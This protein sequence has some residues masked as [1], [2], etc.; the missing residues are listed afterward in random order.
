M[1]IDQLVN[2]GKRVFENNR[3]NRYRISK[4]KWKQFL[5]FIPTLVIILYLI[6]F[7]NDCCVRQTWASSLRTTRG[8]TRIP[9]RTPRG[10]AG[11]DA[12]TSPRPRS[13]PPDSP[14][15]RPRRRNCT[16]RCPLSA[17]TTICSPTAQPTCRPR[18][19][20]SDTA[21]RPQSEN[22]IS[23]GCTRKISTISVPN[24]WCCFTRRAGG[25]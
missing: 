2:I 15:P 23:S 24:E 1:I 3:Y 9:P 25:V 21:T 5:R 12:R 19:P 20:V 4:K 18:S 10:R 16:P 13:P 17:T 11:A 14:A 8:D 7:N 6:W 22:T